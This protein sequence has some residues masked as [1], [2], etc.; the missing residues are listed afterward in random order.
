VVLVLV[1]VVL[2][3]TELC[4][5]LTSA[6]QEMIE[7]EGVQL[8]PADQIPGLPSGMEYVADAVELRLPSAERPDVAAGGER[9]V[10]DVHFPSITPVLPAAD[11]PAPPA[12]FP[13]RLPACS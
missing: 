12:G 3:I 10:T 5:W 11:A 6:A 13:V 7:L 8:W 9:I 4:V 1:V 2:R